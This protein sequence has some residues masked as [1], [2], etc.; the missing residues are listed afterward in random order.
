MQET[1]DNKN[2]QAAK[3]ADAVVDLTMPSIKIAAASDNNSGGQSGAANE[4]VGQLVGGKYQVVSFIGS[5][6]M[7]SVYLVKHLLL[8]KTLAL[9][10]I[11]PHLASDKESLARFQREA[12]ATSRLDH[13]N[14]VKVHDFGISDDGSPYI[15]MDYIEGRT[16]SKAISGKEL[17]T[18]R[19]VHII[20]QSCAALAHAHNR[21]VVHRDI[22]PSN[23]MLVK[24]ETDDFFVKVV[25]F[26]IAQLVVE[27]AEVARLTQTGQIFGTPLYMSPEQCQG[28]RLDA[29]TDIYSLACVMYEALTGKTPFAGSSVYELIFKQI[30][31]APS[32]FGNS[33]PDRQK[34]EALETIIFRALA[35]DPSDRY[36]TMESLKDDLDNVN[37]APAS[38][39]FGFIS[40]FV[41]QWYFRQLTRNLRPM[42]TRIPLIAITVLVLGGIT[43][44]ALLP[45]LQYLQPTPDVWKKLDKEGQV[46]FDRGQKQ[47]ALNTF[48]RAL[49]VAKKLDDK[50]MQLSS[51][52]ELLDIRRA[53]G[54]A[55]QVANIEAELKKLNNPSLQAQ[56]LLEDLT[57]ATQE[58]KGKVTD[59]KE[60]ERLRDLCGSAID[61]AMTL[62][63]QAELPT[64]KA[65]L[66][67]A[68]GI[69]EKA[70]GQ[71]DAL[72]IRCVH[73]LAI[74]AHNQGRYDDAI[75]GYKKAMLVE[76]KLKEKN[77]DMA[78][79]ANVRSMKVLARLYMQIGTNL[80]EAEAL[81]KKA[82]DMSRKAWGPSSDQVGSCRHLLATLYKMEGR[83]NEARREIDTAISIF[84][85]SGKDEDKFAL[86]QAQDMLGRI[87]NDPSYTDKALSTF[88]DMQSK[89]YEALCQLLI[90]AAE[91][92]IME[93]K[94][95]LSAAQSYLDRA[96]VIMERFNKNERDLTAADF[97]PTQAL[98]YEKQGKLDLAE[99]ELRTAL[100]IQLEAGDTD[101][102]NALAIQCRLADVLRNNP[103]TISQAEN[104]YKQ[105][106]SC[107]ESN[108]L[109][110]SSIGNA[111]FFGYARL[112]NAQNRKSEAEQLAERWKNLN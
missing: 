98:L 9:K 61:S 53:R 41:R 60:Q 80:D 69:V 30:N 51:L 96:R 5:G 111:P 16:L 81:L 22:K 28:Q 110:K 36:Q 1:D 49:D 10:M 27:D 88:E 85:H 57:Q 58:L 76:E 63:A 91:I 19:V 43:A 107:L 100:K 84:E 14:L 62:R 66:E 102:L 56:H 108:K 93:T 82:I 7:S 78:N 73:N 26:G 13:P 68:Q 105:I 109:S 50:K 12:E 40:R 4:L 34:K 24:N 15:I 90:R 32:G 64:S 65:I 6:G 8:N 74:V 47:E 112:L 33:V 77:P 101:S 42:L 89:D 71:D 38:G 44:F 31:E 72:M 48:D 39:I 18:D 83:R 103:E 87:T 54:D 92:R 45:Q 46:Q 52:E 94:P 25:D 79:P 2:K 29:R 17:D 37:E 99:K 75:A 97:L 21:S 86:G 59:P 104:L 67:L 55:A 106:F 3:A 95:N 23:I 20:S 11:H 70:F 35:K